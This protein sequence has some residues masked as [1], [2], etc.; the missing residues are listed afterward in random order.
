MRGKRGKG[1]GRKG[2][3]TFVTC[4][5]NG[6]T[7]EVDESELLVG[8]GQESTETR[9]FSF[10]FFF[11]FLFSSFLFFLFFFFFF[12]REPSETVSRIKAKRQS[13]FVSVRR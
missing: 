11:L 12:H 10:P 1:G 6:R 3:D 7:S 13:K 9:F 5:R 8:I 4:V 2:D